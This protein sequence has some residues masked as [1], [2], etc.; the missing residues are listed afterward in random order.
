MVSQPLSGLP[1]APSGFVPPVFPMVPGNPQV[2]SMRSGGTFPLLAAGLVQPVISLPSLQS[3][4]SAANP[5]PSSPGSSQF[6]LGAVFDPSLVDEVEE[7]MNASCSLLHSSLS[8]AGV[9]HDGF[10]ADPSTSPDLQSYN[11]ILDDLGKSDLLVWDLPKPRSLWDQEVKSGAGALNIDP[12][13]VSE[14]TK[15]FQAPSTTMK[16][17]DAASACKV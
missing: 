17:T 13:M 5:S 7:E 16:F 14:L 9:G 11:H 12:G 4:S 10:T 8:E 3:R 1:G 15:A 2:L 6:P